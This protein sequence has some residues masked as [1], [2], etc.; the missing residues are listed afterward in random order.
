MRLNYE[1]YGTHHTERLFRGQEIGAVTE[2]IIINGDAGRG[3]IEHHRNQEEHIAVETP[4]GMAQHPA[5]NGS[6][7]V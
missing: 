6:T 1:E 2:V 7:L 5:L 3:D 4:I